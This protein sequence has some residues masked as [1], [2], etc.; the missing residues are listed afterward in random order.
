[1]LKEAIDKL[2]E[3]A[4]AANQRVITV[5]DKA[6]RST[7]IY[8]PVGEP[9]SVADKPAD[10]QWQ[11]SR[12]ESMVDLIVGRLCEGFS[13]TVV[14][15][16]GGVVAYSGQWNE[17]NPMLPFGDVV[18][19]AWSEACSSPYS[20]TQK[21]LVEWLRDE[22]DGTGLER[23][24]PT[25]RQVEWSR[26]DGAKGLVER[27]RDTLGR[28]VEAA[29]TN[30]ETFPPKVTATLAKLVGATGLSFTFE[31]TVNMEPQAAEQKFSVWFDVD[32]MRDVELAT[33]RSINDAISGD[34]ARALAA[35]PESVQANAGRCVFLS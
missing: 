4:V 13:V 2:G 11:V 5:E 21:Q 19:R 18:T 34:V 15:N 35:L 31:A 12:R 20:F 14:T 10:I 22:M 25:V 17:W 8:P 1:M 6:N 29:V 33:R 24:I 23:L 30:V 9:F 3:L 7:M 32:D 27:G 26:A 16:L 28:S